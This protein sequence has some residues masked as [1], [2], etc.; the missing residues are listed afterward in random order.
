MVLK[1]DKAESYE[2]L[3]EEINAFLTRGV[4]TNAFLSE[5][6]LRLEIGAGTLSFTRAQGALLLFRKRDGHYILNFYITNSFGGFQSALSGLP[7]VAEIMRRPENSGARNALL[8]GGF[9]QYMTRVKL[10]RSAGEPPAGLDASG[11]VEPA[12]PGDEPDCLRI[13]RESLDPY[14]GCVPLLEALER[15]IQEGLVFCA[16]GKA[17]ETAGLLR[18][19]RRMGSTEIRHLAV[20]AAYRR[21]GLASEL[22]AVYLRAAGYNKSSVW[23]SDT[24]AAA[25]RFYQKQGYLDGG[26]RSDVL[27]YNI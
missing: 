16:R 10:V 4:V 7:V 27:V 18:C 5:A 3:R 17:G 22:A 13:L 26:L 11:R 12:C 20:S 24:N 25:L 21:D 23:T 1:V 15:D 9:V 2:A 6:E 14:A 8:Q 19:G